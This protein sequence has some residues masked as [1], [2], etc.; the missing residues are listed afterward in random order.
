MTGVAVYRDS[1]PP[2]PPHGMFVIPS[3]NCLAPGTYNN[4]PG[5]SCSC[6]QYFWL[7]RSLF[8]L[9][10]CPALSQLAGMNVLPVRLTISS[11]MSVVGLR[12]L[13]D[14]VAPFLGLSQ[15]TRHE[16]MRLHCLPFPLTLIH[17]ALR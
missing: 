9:Q 14:I 12:Q 4:D 2:G 1:P 6:L 10:L 17:M 11:F 16:Q 13:Q 7:Q 3:Q 15:M 8:Q 5:A